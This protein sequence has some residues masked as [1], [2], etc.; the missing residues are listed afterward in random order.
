MRAACNR[1]KCLSS[2]THA[3]QTHLGLVTGLAAAFGTAAAL[4]FSPSPATLAFASLSL[5]FLGPPSLPLPE[6]AAALSL[7]FG[8]KVSRGGGGT[9]C[10]HC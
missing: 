10:M 3:C 9:A 2:C 5:F 4:A 7:A 8:L 6:S 1:G